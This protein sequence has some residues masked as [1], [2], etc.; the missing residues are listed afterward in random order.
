MWVELFTCL[1]LAH[2]VADF[3][4]Q[5]SRVCDDKR[6]K[7][8]KS[9]YHY[10]HAIIVF[11]LSL[12]V[13]WDI[14]FWWCA[15]LIGL[16]HFLIDIWK[17][18]KK[19]ELKWF[20]IDQILHI[21]ILICVSYFWLDKRGWSIP[22]DLNV[23]TVATVVAVVLCSK[24]ANILIKL[25]LKH[26]SLGVSENQPRPGFKAGAL[27]GCLERWLILIFVILQNYEAL[28]LLVAAKSIIRF[29]D[30]ESR[31]QS[32]YVLAG[33]LLSIFIAVVSGLFV[34]QF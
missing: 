16:S 15:A 4:L 18:Y 32:E 8:W 26:H 14:R 2:L 5:S 21:F 29:G 25:V 31:N 27:I 28:G 9:L 3:L 30:S 10:I 20:V 22:F 17:S 34:S 19:D 1:L 7:K 6:E 33:T 24:P 11:G 13:V 12:L 23:Q